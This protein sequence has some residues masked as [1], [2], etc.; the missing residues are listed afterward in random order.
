M[1]KNT[2][3]YASIIA[4]AFNNIS[5]LHS[6]TILTHGIACSHTF[7]SETKYCYSRNDV[8]SQLV[9]FSAV[10]PSSTWKRANLQTLQ[11]HRKLTKIVTTIIFSQWWSGEKGDLY[12]RKNVW[13]LLAL[14]RSIN[15]LST[16]TSFYW[17]WT[18]KLVQ[19]F[20]NL[21]HV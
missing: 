15:V 19:G 7:F 1:K 11:I 16:F 14:Q 8:R 18:A 12:Q 5:S 20:T 4:T 17:G 9:P 6:A 21:V 3:F 13:S 10:P 2:L